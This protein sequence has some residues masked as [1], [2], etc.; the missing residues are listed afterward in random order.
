MRWIPSRNLH[1][2]LKF[3]GDVENRRVPELCSAVQRAAE[4]L[5]CDP[6]ETNRSDR[7]HDE[8][9][10]A[11]AA[12]ELA[13]LGCFPHGGKA[14]VVWAGVRPRGPGVLSCY[15]ALESEFTELGFVPEARRFSPHITLARVRGSGDVAALRT[16]VE[17]QD[18][19]GPQQRPSELVL[20]ESSPTPSG[21]EYLA[22]AR[23][24]F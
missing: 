20:F 4:A 11:V 23:A 14:R 5:E 13:G 19:V 21:V 24:P 22:L 8:N 17:T 9:I 3:L 1:L 6:N 18:F 7:S 16:A 12:F 2:T 10:V 15:N